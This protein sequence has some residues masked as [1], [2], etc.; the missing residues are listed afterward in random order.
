MKSAVEADVKILFEFGAGKRIDVGHGVGPRVKR[1]FSFVARKVKESD[2]DIDN[3]LPILEYIARKYSRVW[4]LVASLYE[5][6]EIQ[7]YRRK[8]I[9]AIESYLES[10]PVGMDAH[11]AWSRL[12][13]MYQFERDAVGEVHALLELSQLAETPFSEISN[14]VNRLNLLFK[15]QQ[16]ILDTDEKNYLVRNFVKVMESCV[17]EADSTDC[18]R[19]AWL[20]LHMNDETRAERYVELG[21]KI[22][23]YNQY[24]LNLKER[25]I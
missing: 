20:C 10:S 6:L 4:L 11:N 17:K 14:S 2:E 18:S 25:L 23:P 12:S 15:N 24:Y 13:K 16:L 22:E 5:E 21:L 3:Y 8:A 19:L 1:L 9:N 7:G